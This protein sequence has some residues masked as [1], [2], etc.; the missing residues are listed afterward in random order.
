MLVVTELT[1]QAYAGA[2]KSLKERK[3]FA[4]VGPAGT[5]KTETIKDLAMKLGRKV[6]TINCNVLSSESA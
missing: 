6:F 1:E 5:G 2:V 4:A 3:P